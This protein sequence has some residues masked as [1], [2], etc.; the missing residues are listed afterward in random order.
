[1]KAERKATKDLVDELDGRAL[2]A[3]VEAL[4]NANAGAIV[5]RGELIETPPRRWDALQKRDIDLKQM[6]RPK[7]LITL[8]PPPIRAM[9]LIGRQSIHAVALAY[10]MH[11]GS[12]IVS[13]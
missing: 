5:D 8:P 13:W 4:E 9:L 2:I 11:R 7:C 3:G 12:A 6:A 1:M 10:A